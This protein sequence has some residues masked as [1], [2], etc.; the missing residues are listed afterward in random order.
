MTKKIRPDYEASDSMG[1]PYVRK[2]R[3]IGELATSETKDALVEATSA[4]AKLINVEASGIIK[5][6]TPAFLVFGMNRNVAKRH[7]QADLLL[8]CGCDLS[9]DFCESFEP[10]SSETGSLSE[11]L[12]PRVK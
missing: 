11:G 6:G 7:A 8:T 1:F 12:S 5:Y 9:L 4:I 10:A 2:A 3:V